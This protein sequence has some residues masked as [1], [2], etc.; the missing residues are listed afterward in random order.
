MPDYSQANYLFLLRRAD[1]LRRRTFITDSQA[2][3]YQAIR[4]EIEKREQETAFGIPDAWVNDDAALLSAA[5]S[6]TPSTG[7]NRQL[8]FYSE[9]HKALDTNANK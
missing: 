6:D 8:I 2:A 4:A 5:I 9:A 7:E 3:H 1:W